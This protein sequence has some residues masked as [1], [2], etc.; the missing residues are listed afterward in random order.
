MNPASLPGILMVS[1]EPPASME[2]EFNDWYDTEHFPQRRALPGFASASRW[3]CTSG[4]PRWTALYDLVSMD[5]LQTDAYRA[6]S[7]ANSTPWSRR[8]LPRTVGRTRVVAVALDAAQAVAQ[9][10]PRSTCRLLAMSV[11]A[12]AK[13]GEAQAVAGEIR[14]KLVTRG[15]LQQIRWFVENDDVLWTLAAF[16]TPASADVLAAQLGRPGGSGML[17]FNVYAPYHRSTY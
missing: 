4:W 16:D 13:D 3:V 5:A 7:G 12:R 6:V 14:E 11:R 17:S 15:D 2:E 10:E 8:L 9:H 1:M